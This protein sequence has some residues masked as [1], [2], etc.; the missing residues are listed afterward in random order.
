M[1]NPGELRRAPSPPQPSGHG[2]DLLADRD[3][4]LLVAQADPA[5]RAVTEQATDRCETGGPSEP[6]LDHARTVAQGL[7]LRN[8]EQLRALAVLAR[9]LTG[10]QR[11]GAE[12]LEGVGTS[13]IGRADLPRGIRTPER[14]PGRHGDLRLGAVETT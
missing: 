5:D 2:P 10:A 12:L 11:D 6:E 8:D 14:V 13:L 3:S 9:R 1:S 7:L 4:D